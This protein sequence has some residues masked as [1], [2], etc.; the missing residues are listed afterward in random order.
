MKNLNGLLETI[1]AAVNALDN[2][3]LTEC[4]EFVNN[5][6]NESLNEGHD[7]EFGKTYAER[8]K[9]NDNVMY[10]TGLNDYADSFNRD[11]EHYNLGD[12]IDLLTELDEAIEALKDAASDEYGSV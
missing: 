12:Y 5:Y 11:N 7:D 8:M 1:K 3:E 9:E 2:F 10:R 4:D 6:Y